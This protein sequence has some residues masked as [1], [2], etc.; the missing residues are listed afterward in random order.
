MD[1]EIKR[2]LGDKAEVVV[3][4]PAPTEKEEYIKFWYR[5]KAQLKISYRLFIFFLNQLGF[6]LSFNGKDYLLVRVRNNIVEEVSTVEIKDAVKGYL[7][8][9]QDKFDEGVKAEDLLELVINQSPTLF[10]RGNLEYLE[11]IE[12]EFKQDTRTESFIYFKNCFVRVTSEEYSVH[13]YEELDKPIWKNQILEREF[14]ESGGDC[15]FQTFIFRI[16]GNDS[17]RY[18]SFR[19]VIG[20]LLH[21][22]KDPALAKAII[23]MDEKLDDG[24]NGGCGK[25]LLGN[26]ISKIR[27]SLRLGGKNFFFERFA[28][29]SYEPGTGI[30]EFNDLSR[31]FKFENLFTAI[32]DNIIIEKKNKDELIIPFEH[33]P[34]ILLSTN[35]TIKGVDEST[36]RR[37]FVLE[38]SD[39]FSIRYSPEDEFGHRFFDDWC[40][41]EWCRFYSFMI[42]CLQF[43]L[44][45]GL[46][47][48]ERKNLEVKKLI[49]STSEEFLEFVEDLAKDT[50]HDKRET[51][52]NFLENYP[53]FNNNKMEQKKFTS[54]LK[55]F[56][57]IKGW[58]FIQRRSG[59][60]RMFILNSVL[61]IQGEGD[62]I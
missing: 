28:F 20:Y 56:A 21:G 22:Y 8:E 37:Q 38:F 44:H 51:Y 27:K 50:W 59:T 45:K 49:E 47:E 53:D 41:N 31:S 14:Y 6:R 9:T 58:K 30:I 57:R 19:S 60:D 32:T 25:S 54:W 11:Q 40:N 26:A 16:S 15:D 18:D 17:G 36:L 1:Q 2:I 61:D 13:N 29:Q 43:Y 52:R 23:F 46:L 33:S 55:I 7:Q 34:K 5:Q 24:S 3:I 12:E 10:C 62:L 35:Y 48:Y 4:K 39:Y 42:G